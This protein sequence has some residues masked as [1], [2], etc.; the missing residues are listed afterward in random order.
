MD[1]FRDFPRIFPPQIQGI[2]DKFRE[3]LKQNPL[4][5]TL[6]GLYIIHRALKHR[7]KEGEKAKA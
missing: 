5:Y 2:V 3:Y 6:I 4:A 1:K 7:N